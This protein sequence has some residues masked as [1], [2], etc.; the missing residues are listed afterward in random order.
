M[1]LYSPTK[2]VHLDVVSD[3]SIMEIRQRL[4]VYLDDLLIVSP[5]FATHLNKLTHF[6]RTYDLQ[7]L[8][9]MRCGEE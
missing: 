7:I 1:F 8:E 6:Q 5:D 3:Q 4:F 2:A 9:S